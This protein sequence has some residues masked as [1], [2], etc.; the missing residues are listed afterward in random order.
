VVS[1]ERDTIYKSVQMLHSVKQYADFNKAL[2][3][4]RIPYTVKWAG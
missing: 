3:N 2:F 4:Y 1:I